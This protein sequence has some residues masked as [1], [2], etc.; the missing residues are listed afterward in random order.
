MGATF[1]PGSELHGLRGRVFKIHEILQGAELVSDVPS[2]TPNPQLATQYT[3]S[4]EKSY[5]SVNA[6]TTMTLSQDFC[7]I[8]QELVS[9][10]AHIQTRTGQDPGYTSIATMLG[11]PPGVIDQE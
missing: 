5:T 1:C 9:Y 10:H 2:E 11:L 8:A 3:Y 4:H 7:K 6:L